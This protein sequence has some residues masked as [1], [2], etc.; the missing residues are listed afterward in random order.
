MRQSP[1][2]LYNIARK[3]FLIFK[4]ERQKLLLKNNS[5]IFILIYPFLFR[6][7]LSLAINRVKDERLIWINLFMKL[8]EYRF[9]REILGV[10]FL[11]RSFPFFLY[12]NFSNVIR[13]FTVLEKITLKYKFYIRLL[14]HPRYFWKLIFIRLPLYL[15]RTSPQ[16]CDNNNFIILNYFFPVFQGPVS[17]FLVKF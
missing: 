10:N 15:V 3:V 16:A 9:Y 1:V 7:S 11:L 6:T 8:T 5:I 4:S 2:F 13:P 12:L 14:F 17:I